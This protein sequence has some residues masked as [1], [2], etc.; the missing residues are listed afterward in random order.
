[1]RRRHRPSTSEHLTQWRPHRFDDLPI[2]LS[3]AAHER[4]GVLEEALRL[5]AMYMEQAD[6][7]VKGKAPWHPEPRTVLEAFWEVHTILTHHVVQHNGV[8]DAVRPVAHSFRQR[9][10]HVFLPLTGLEVDNRMWKEAS[11]A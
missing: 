1:M 7:E 11:V 9:V 4:R 8:L 2:H 5:V 6:A 10:I 3:G